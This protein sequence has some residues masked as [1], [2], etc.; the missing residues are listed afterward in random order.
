MQAEHR[1]S[2]RT[3]PPGPQP[4]HHQLAVTNRANYSEYASGAGQHNTFSQEQPPDVRSGEA[5]GSKRSDLA[6]PLLDAQ[7]EKETSKERRRYQEEAE[8]DEVLAKISRAARRFEALTA[9][10]LN[11]KSYDGRV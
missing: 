10:R 6:Q 11:R 5:N 8:V 4:V 2:D 9:H 1:G 3:D 7:L